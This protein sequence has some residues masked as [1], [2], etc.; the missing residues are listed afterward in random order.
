VSLVTVTA[1]QGFPKFLATVLLLAFTFYMPVEMARLSWF[2]FWQESP[3]PELYGRGQGSGGINDNSV[4][5]GSIAGYYFFG[6]PTG[7]QPVAEN[8]RRSAPETRLRLTLE[9]VLVAAQPASSGA[10]VAGSNGE[11]AYY[12][13]GD[14]LPGNAELAEVESG[15]ILIRRGGQYETLAFEEQVSAQKVVAQEV[16]KPSE[17]PDAFLARARNQLEAQGVRALASY[18]LQPVRESG[19]SGYVYDGS[20]PLLNA[21]N[22]RAGDVITAINGQ[23]LGDIEQDKALLNSWRSSPRLDIEIERNGAILSV[24]Y[25]IPEQWR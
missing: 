12:R 24:S 15:S 11:T 2:L 10:I 5:V 20:N 3:V 8:V 6:K 25:A 21:V 22:L 16:E 19:Q 17:S 14:V 9:G 4:S 18:G 13:V 23:R 7:Q 1:S